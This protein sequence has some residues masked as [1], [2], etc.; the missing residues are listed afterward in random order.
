[1]KYLPVK[2]LISREIYIVHGRARHFDSDSHSDND[3]VLSGL[4][5]G[6]VKMVQILISM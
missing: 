6:I 5:S 4:D 3:K 1:M 2:I